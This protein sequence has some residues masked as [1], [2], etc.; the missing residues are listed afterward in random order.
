M[1]HRVIF[2]SPHLDKPGK[3]HDLALRFMSIA[4][5]SLDIELTGI[6]ATT[7]SDLSSTVRDLLATPERPHGAVIINAKNVA[8]T[9]LKILDE[10]SVHSVVA[11]EGFYETDRAQV[12]L[13]GS[14]LKY[15][16]SE[17]MPDDLEVGRLLARTLIDRAAAE[18]RRGPDGKIRVL[19]L[20]GPFTQAATNRLT[21]FR[22]TVQ[23]SGHE[24]A[25]D[26]RMADWSQ[27]KGYRL[28]TEYLESFRP[29]VIWAANDSIARGAAR[30]LDE[31]DLKP[32]EDVLV[33]GV[34]WIGDSLRDVEQGRFTTSVGGHILDGIW[35]L[36]MIRDALDGKLPP[37]ERRI[38]SSMVAATADDASRYLRAVDESYLRTIDFAARFSR[39]DGRY[40]FSL[41]RLL[42]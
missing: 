9:Q 19:T 5:K 28:T 1:G 27:E 20:S 10:E 7:M 33:G 12:G 6:D 31:A 39:S 40:D 17:I 29:Q 34:D 4:S 35:A 32:G 42:D 18:D 21:G 11:Y 3:F 25:Y 16:R 2:I 14:P 22:E 13:P 37:V 24:V 38:A 8:A 41:D 23:T 26:L 36:V 15:W 30:A